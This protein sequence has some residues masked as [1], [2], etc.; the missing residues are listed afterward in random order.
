[1]LSSK[2][3]INLKHQTRTRGSHEFTTELGRSSGYC[4][5]CKIDFAS[6]GKTFKAPRIASACRRCG[7]V[8]QC[9]NVCGDVVAFGF[10]LVSQDDWELLAAGDRE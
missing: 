6:T 8:G 10:R 4:A 1:M 2:E 9:S 5:V 3:T 7:I